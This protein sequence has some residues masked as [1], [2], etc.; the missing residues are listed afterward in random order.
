VGIFADGTYGV[1]WNGVGAGSYLGHAGQGV[2]GLLHGDVRQFLCQLLGATL[3]AI[4]AFGA[5]YV[6]FSLVNKK[7][8]MRVAPQIEVEGLD[9]P[10]FGLPGY[11]E[12]AG[13][14]ATY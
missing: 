9:I 3:C 6:V 10:E 11:S 8:P 4:W 2:T 1:G 13:V 14:T 5:T 7:K 12:E